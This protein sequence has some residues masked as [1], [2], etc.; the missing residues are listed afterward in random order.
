MKST[1]QRKA[2]LFCDYHLWHSEMQFH[3]WG[4]R[5]SEDTG[6][7]SKWAWEGRSSGKGIMHLRTD[8]ELTGAR[9]WDTENKTFS[10][11][12]TTLGC[13]VPDMSCCLEYLNMHS[14]QR[15]EKLGRLYLGFNLVQCLLTSY[16]H[17]EVD[18]PFLS[19]ICP[20][21]LHIL[22]SLSFLL[23]VFNF[24]SFSFFSLNLSILLILLTSRDEDN[25]IPCT[26]EN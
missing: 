14:L 26:Q 3:S 16:G 5:R 4:G 13:V 24:I 22:S 7:K 15:N 18:L 21:S 17:S 6:F 25:H 1:K 10:F 8:R 2:I 9:L 19:F 12:L 23:L 20:V 11:Y